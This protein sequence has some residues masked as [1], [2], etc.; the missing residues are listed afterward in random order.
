[1]LISLAH[2]EPGIRPRSSTTL[3]ALTSYVFKPPRDERLPVTFRIPEPA[4]RPFAEGAISSAFVPTV[5]RVLTLEGRRPPGAWAPRPRRLL[6]ATVS[7]W[8]WRSSSPDHRPSP[9][10]FAPSPASGAGG[11]AGAGDVPLL[12]LIAVPIRFMGMLNSLH[13]SF[14]RPS[15]QPFERRDLE[16][17]GLPHS[18][19]PVEGI[20]PIYAWPSAR[21]WRARRIRR[22]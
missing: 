18:R 13:R 10:D 17:D 15:P 7:W 22:S 16:D 20:H 2:D 14:A 5:T 11:I 3:L 4:P 21:S 9:P 12:T 19:L 1:M 6:L 8:S